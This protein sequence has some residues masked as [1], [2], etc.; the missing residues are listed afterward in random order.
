MTATPAAMA[1]ARRR[2]RPEYIEIESVGFISRCQTRS[3]FGKPLGRADVLPQAGVELAAQQP[4][5]RRRAQERRKGR[6][7]AC[8]HL[9]E[10][11][12]RHDRYARISVALTRAVADEAVV[13]RE[14]AARA[15]RRIRHQDQ[16]PE[17]SAE[18]HPPQAGK[19]R[20]AINVRIDQPEGLSADAD[21]PTGEDHGG[22][23]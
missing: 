8:L 12:R 4:A 19:I 13:E 7:F 9:R 3:Q 20:L 22:L 14:I 11:R 18:L 17:A 2:R 10:E 15:V 5:L 21:G 23:D 16:M 1:S 6:F